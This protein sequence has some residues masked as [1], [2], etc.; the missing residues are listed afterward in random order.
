MHDRNCQAVGLLCSRSSGVIVGLASSGIK[1]GP[2]TKR[3]KCWVCKKGQ[4]SNEL[5]PFC[6]RHREYGRWET[7]CG[8]WVH[9]RGLDNIQCF[10]RK[11]FSVPIYIRSIS[12]KEG[13]LL[14][15]LTSPTR[16]SPI[17]FL[18]LSESLVVIIV[19]FKVIV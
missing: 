4:A 8:Q 19:T 5:T 14:L 7:I 2:A 6:Q 10:L 16:N 18:A 15:S 9:R 13:L 17:S 3:G 12:L 11:L 1:P